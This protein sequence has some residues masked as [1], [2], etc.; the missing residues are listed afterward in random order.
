M[1]L[2]KYA[3]W[4]FI[5]QLPGVLGTLVVQGSLCHWYSMLN[6]PSVA[7]PE[8]VYGSAWLVLYLLMGSA[9]F[10][11][12]KDGVTSK[13]RKA[14]VLFLA[15]LVVNALWTP[16]FFGLHSI[17]GGVAVLAA[18]IGLAAWTTWEFKKLSK[19]AFWL[20]APYLLWLLY[21]MFINI[22]FLRLN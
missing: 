16:V 21:A 17:V 15:Q 4:L 22:S 6:R 5:C 9:I 18:L 3:L 11:V 20:M 7:P 14:L 10:L 19:P 2:G 12:V 1:Q 13:N 8:W